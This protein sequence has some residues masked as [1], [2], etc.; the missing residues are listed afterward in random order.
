MLPTTQDNKTLIRWS[1]T[2]CNEKDN[3]DKEGVGENE[4]NCKT[5]DDQH[6]IANPHT[7]VLT[8]SCSPPWSSHSYGNE[9]NTQAPD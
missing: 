8:G 3:T 9:G 4:E 5:N 1:I 7:V 6:P 2:C